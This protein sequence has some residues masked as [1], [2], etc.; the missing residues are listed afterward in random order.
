MRVGS[1][2]LFVALQIMLF[3][4]QPAVARVHRQF[5]RT[6]ARD[7]GGENQP[8]AALLRAR[9]RQGDRLSGRRRACRPRLVGHDL[10]LRASASGRTGR[11]RR[12]S[13]ATVGLPTVIPG[14]SPAQSDG[15]GRA[16][17]RG[18]RIRHPW[19]QCAGLDRRLRLL[20]LHP[21]AQFRHHGSVRAACISAPGWWCDDHTEAYGVRPH[22]GG[23]AFL[24][25]SSAHTLSFSRGGA[26]RVLN[27]LP[28]CSLPQKMR[29]RSAVKRWRVASPPGGDP[30]GYAPPSCE[31]GGG[32]CER[33]CASRRSTAAFFL[34]PRTTP[35]L[36]R[37]GILHPEH[38]GFRLRSS[39]RRRQSRR[40]S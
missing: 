28:V 1:L 36:I 25:V 38:A 30:C 37:T 24:F 12:R 31:E 23:A 10:H 40:P 8:A 6:C 32:R 26:P 18:R 33:P 29:E 15:R 13:G 35:S 14:G 16:H 3:G 17:A 20:W 27:L 7:G 2:V 22:D 39:G 4:A 21:H 11:R 5:Q 34:S 9:R 19:H